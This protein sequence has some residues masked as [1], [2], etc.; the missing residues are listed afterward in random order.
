[1]CLQVRGMGS[2][3]KALVDEPHGS[4]ADATSAAAS[5]AT[6]S[7]A[8]AGR[9]PRDERRLEGAGSTAVPDSASHPHNSTAAFEEEQKDGGEHGGTSSKALC[10]CSSY[11]ALDAALNASGEVGSSCRAAASSSRTASPA[12]L[13][14]PLADAHSHAPPHPPQPDAAAADG[15]PGRC[16]EA[17]AGDG[18]AESAAPA[19]ANAEVATLY[20]L[21]VEHLQ[22]ASGLGSWWWRRLLG[23]QAS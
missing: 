8:A 9:V 1:M 21:S 19:A 17:A 5:C 23:V 20:S 2:G 14:T 18:G 3:A 7:A 10:S 13:E 22:Q 12:T 15:E 16:S 6:A 11:V 4:V